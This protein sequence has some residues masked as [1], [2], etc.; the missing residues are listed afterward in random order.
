MVYVMPLTHVV[1]DIYKWANGSLA[2]RFLL[3]AFL[4]RKAHFMA[5]DKLCS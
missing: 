2:V 4:Y 1:H 5:A 3:E